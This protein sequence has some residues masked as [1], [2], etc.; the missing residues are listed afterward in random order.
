[1][2]K[3]LFLVLLIG[4]AASVISDDRPKA[5]AGFDP[6]VDIIA[7]N[8]EAGAYL[9]YDCEEGHWVC[10]TAAYYKECELKREQDLQTDLVRGRC[11]PLG[12]LPTKKSC[13][14]RQLFMTGHNHGNRFCIL[15]EWKEKEILLEESN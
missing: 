9:I 4:S 1:M 5:L 8:Y 15:P 13:F 3:V 14:Q 6:K 2:N 11:A 10:V 7:E 12:G